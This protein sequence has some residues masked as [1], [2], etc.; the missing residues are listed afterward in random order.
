CSN[1]GGMCNYLFPRVIQMMPLFHPVR[2]DQDVISW[3]NDRFQRVPIWLTVI[4]NIELQKPKWLSDAWIDGVGWI[5]PLRS[6][7]TG[8]FGINL[9]RIEGG[10]RRI[11]RVSTTAKRNK[12]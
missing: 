2:L 4:T 8:N 12:T 7:L 10:S 3:A 6:Q 1:D 9:R 5:C 11:C